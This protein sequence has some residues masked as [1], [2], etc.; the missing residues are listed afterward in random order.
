MGRRN[1]FHRER[2]AEYRCSGLRRDRH[3][4]LELRFP[5]QYDAPHVL[6]GEGGFTSVPAGARG[7]AAPGKPFAG[8]ALLRRTEPREDDKHGKQPV[9]DSAQREMTSRF[10][11][12]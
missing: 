10:D 11:Y 8:L 7:I 1:V 4:L 3:I 12:G 2:R 9:A 5:L 6:F